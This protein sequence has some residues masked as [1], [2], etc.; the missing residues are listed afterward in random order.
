MSFHRTLAAPALPALL[1]V[2]FA[3]PVVA[4]SVVPSDP[5]ATLQEQ[6][7]EEP[8]SDP[9]RPSG[10]PVEEEIVVTASRSPEPARE[11]GSSVTVLDRDEIERRGVATVLELLRTV[12]GVEVSQGGGPGRVASV[13][14]RGATSAQTLVLLDGVRLNSPA[15]AA[16]DL[17][18]LTVDGVERVEILRG[19][20][21]VL[22]GSEAMGGV[23]SITTRRAS[24][25]LAG[26][27]EAE[28]G[29]VLTLR[30]GTRIVLQDGFRVASG[31]TL[32]LEVF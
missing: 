12:P 24:D 11:V 15:T 26:G 22:Y 19:P 30:A 8:P 7:Q 32:T 23:V 29:G 1:A 4:S 17:A 25:G 27:V 6:S 16:F 31:G 14:L 18:D 5:E 21:S 9:D 20:Q 10:P 28:A 2:V 3:V 13:F